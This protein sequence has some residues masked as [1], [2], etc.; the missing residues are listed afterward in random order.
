VEK[1][2][3]QIHS[4][5]SRSGHV[6]ELQES[7]SNSKRPYVA[8][9]MQ[10]VHDVLDGRIPACKQVRQACER[11]LRDLERQSSD[12]FR[13]VF[14]Q[15]SAEYACEFLEGFSHVK[16]EW[17]KRKERLRM[18]PWQIFIVISLFGWVAAES[19]TTYRFR[20]AVLIIPRKNGKSFLAAAIALFKF[21]ADNEYSAEVYFGATSEA[22]AKRLGFS[23]A[24]Q[25]AKG[26]ESFQKAFG[27]KVNAH[28]LTREDGS[29][30]KAIIANPG[31]G[32]SP[33]CAVMDEYHE[34]RNAEQYNT[35]KT[36]MGA[37]EN[38]LALVIS[39]AGS[40]QAGPCYLLQKD[41]E[42]ILAGTTQNDR[43]FAIIFTID[44][45]D[46][47]KTVEAQRKAN[48]NYGV[49]VRADYLEDE[50]RTA[51]QSP[52]K[53]TAYKTKHL[54]IWVNAG[55]AWIPKEVW[56]AI[57]EAGLSLEDFVGEEAIVS[58]DLA[59]E[60]DIASKV[61]VFRKDLEDREDPD[62][63]LFAKHY[64]HEAALEDG[65]NESYVEWAEAGWL[66]ITS[67]NVTSYPQI[68]REL[69]TDADKFNILEIPHDPYH[70]APLIQFVQED[71]EWDQNIEFTKFVQNVANFSP[72]MKQ[73]EKLAISKRLH[74]NGDPVLAWMISNVV[75][76]T[77]SK[78]NIMPDKES[79]DRKIDGA[80]AGIMAISRSGSLTG[81]LQGI[82]VQ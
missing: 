29:I 5:S 31:D 7:S 56:D 52:R 57:A 65:R 19:R 54:N 22:Q 74:H 32:D 34:H 30:L 41:A 10:Y 72:A 37:R 21:A 49:S 70:A 40:N 45:G 3:Q 26:A 36:G 75:C 79:P 60:V 12:G 59:N 66:T 20:E 15:E 11:H 8:L 27:V 23:A 42:K 58:F 9:A 77:V 82:F 76:K 28:N 6:D 69:K 50:L 17:A 35:M 55:V 25:M 13:W 46:D 53:Q 47:W 43:I 81:R 51:L 14:D 78:D 4:V 67:G 64:I 2:N 38:P 16:G 18:S 63:Y 80:V 44:E 39:T 73:F 62:F 33:S 24:R 71:E 48:P 1:T 68:A 61:Y